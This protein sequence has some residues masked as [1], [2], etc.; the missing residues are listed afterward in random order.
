[1]GLFKKNAPLKGCIKSADEKA[2]SLTGQSSHSDQFGRRNG[3]ARRG[4]PQH[5][6]QC[7]ARSKTPDKQGIK[8]EV[9]DCENI[10]QF[11][12]REEYSQW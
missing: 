12:V 1:M 3:V 7:N 4:R 5:H 8:N 6:G 9:T 11:D 2:A 10:S